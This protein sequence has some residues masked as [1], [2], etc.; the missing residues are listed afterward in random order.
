MSPA[1]Q[2]LFSLRARLDKLERENRWMRRLAVLVV[3]AFGVVALA[4]AQQKDEPKS[5]ILTDAQGKERGRLGMGKEG[6][7]LH[8]SDENGKARG[9]LEMGKGGISLRFT[10]DKGRLIAGLSLEPEGVAVVASDRNNKLLVG[11][12]AV[13]NNTGVLLAPEPEKKP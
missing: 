10:D 11:P 13:Q 12:N 4:A 8:F 7:F 2:D 3:I 6:P 1:E 9:G 5:Y